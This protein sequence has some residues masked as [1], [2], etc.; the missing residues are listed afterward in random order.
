MSVADI[1]SRYLRSRTRTAIHERAARLQLTS[2]VTPWSAAEIRALRA[3]YAR[4]TIGALIERYLPRRSA[5]SVQ[6]KAA[7]L[8]LTAPASLDWTK[9][10][11]SL[12]RT[13]Y[14]SLS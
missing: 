1:Q 8:G 13:H 6:A 7:K 11:E 9:K 4:L 12:L 3:L 14:G 5:K 10:E 2:D